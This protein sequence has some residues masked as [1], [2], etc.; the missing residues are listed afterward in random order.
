MTVVRVFS[1]VTGGHLDKVDQSD[2]RKRT[3]HSRKVDCGQSA[4]RK[5]TMAVFT[6][7][8]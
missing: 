7:G 2:Y 6:L 5:K 4:A 8:C 1:T 3:K